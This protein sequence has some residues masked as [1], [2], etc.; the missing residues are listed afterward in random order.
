[1]STEIDQQIEALNLR[2]QELE[3]KIAA[4][5]EQGARAAVLE[6]L[7]MAPRHIFFRNNANIIFDTETQLLWT[8][9]GTNHS[10]TEIIY[11]GI[12]EL[13][14]SL[15]KASDN[16]DRTEQEVLSKKI[17]SLVQQ[18]ERF[19]FKNWAIPYLQNY[20][21]VADNAPIKSPRHDK[22]ICRNSYNSDSVYYHAFILSGCFPCQLEYCNGANG[23]HNDYNF[24]DSIKNLFLI[25]S[26]LWVR[27]Y[28]ITNLDKYSDIERQQLIQKNY[29]EKLNDQLNM[30]LK[31]GLAPVLNKSSANKSFDILLQELPPLK[32]LFCDVE[33]ALQQANNE[34]KKQ[35]E[36][37]SSKFDYRYLLDHL[38]LDCDTIDSSVVKYA[39]ATL[40]WSTVLL[41]KIA[42]YEMRQATLITR[43][44]EVTA[45]LRSKFHP[46]P[47]LTGQ[48]NQLLADRQQFMQQRFNLDFAHVKTCVAGL[49][50]QGQT[51]KK[52]LSDTNALPDS[53][54]QLGSIHH[55]V[56]AP[57]DL[58]AE[59][60]A[61]Q[62]IDKLRQMEFY[63]DNTALFEYLVATE[64]RWADDFKAL[65][66]SKTNTLVQKCQEEG[67]ESEDYQQWL[68]DWYELRL[69]LEVSLQPLLECGIESRLN[70]HQRSQSPALMLIEALEK[71][72]QAIDNYYL[73]DRAGVHQNLAFAANARIQE[74]LAVETDLYKLSVVFQQ[75]LQSIIFSLD[76][77]EQ[78]LF[79]FH[80]A[81]RITE[82]SVGNVVD[83]IRDQ[84]LDQL[85]QALLNDFTQLRLRNYA[86]FIDDAQHYAREIK[87]Q[88]KS[89]NA[90]M[91]KM[92][93]ELA[94]SKLEAA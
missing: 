68:A 44:K 57:F 21:N 35:R 69:Q 63:E 87:E 47:N 39:D 81:D 48:E 46:E 62:I 85:S 1:M 27:D 2:K 88:E 71:Y 45:G 6:G 7:R 80:W 26:S 53:I 79:V 31:H 37:L 42:E 52:Q 20:K 94:N 24:T 54:S 58:L 16:Q 65:K 93:K 38:K 28:T 74:R 59:N 76:D 4:L 72:K 77:M 14:S 86:C 56:R 73:N 89:Y 50:H 61:M 70:L 10:A 64:Q 25:N 5:D 83:F 75:A 19:G 23:A 43:S 91:F 92:R 32:Q 51:L 8:S 90:L 60:T 40:Q 11:P 36:L 13:V 34:K 17:R 66:T 41:S 49:K 12:Q 33:A 30:Y 15:K 84:Q 9:G 82:L 55:N 29:A 22:D 3:G 78:R 18:K 67:V